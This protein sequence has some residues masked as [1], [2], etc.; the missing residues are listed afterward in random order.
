M[1]KSSVP[2]A[3]S[4]NTVLSKLVS[5]FVFVALVALVV[6]HPVE[7]A[8]WTTG[9]F[10]ALGDAMSGLMTFLQQVGG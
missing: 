1:A 9:G 10:S 6:K 2:M 8:H 5:G 7:A 3:K 4:G